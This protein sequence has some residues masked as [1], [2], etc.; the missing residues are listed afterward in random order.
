M[1]KWIVCVLIVGLLVLV[2]PAAAQEDTGIPI[3]YGDTVEGMIEP[4]ET[5]RY[6]FECQEGDVILVEVTSETLRMDVDVQT[7]AEGGSAYSN[8]YTAQLDGMVRESGRCGITVKASGLTDTGSSDPN[9]SGA[10]TL[11]LTLTETVDPDAEPDRF[12]ITY[13]ETLSYEMPPDGFIYFD[14]AGQVGDVVLATATGEGFDDDLYG[15]IGN[16]NTGWNETSR[17]LKPIE[18]STETVIYVTILPADG[19]YSMTLGNAGSSSGL[20]TMMLERVGNHSADSGRS[21]AYGEAVGAHLNTDL[22]QRWWFEGQAGDLADISVL[23]PVVTGGGIVELRV[24]A[25][26]GT[27]LNPPTF[28]D[29]F[30]SQSYT[31]RAVVK[32]P[33]TGT[34]RA[35]IVRYPQPGD[36]EI[37]PFDYV[38]RLDRPSATALGYGQM[39]TGELAS[40]ADSAIFTFEASA[41]D[42]VLVN[43]QSDDLDHITYRLSA[44]AAPIF[45]DGTYSHRWILLDSGPFTVEVYNDQG[46]YGDGG[47]FT[48][49]LEQFSTATITPISTGEPL[50]ISLDGTVAP[51]LS[52]EGKADDIVSV[53]VPSG[54]FISYTVVGGPGLYAEDVAAGPQSGSLLPYLRLPQDGTYYILPHNYHGQAPGGYTVPVLISQGADEPGIVYGETISGTIGADSVGIH[55][56]IGSAGDQVSALVQGNGFMAD[57]YLFGPGGL[58]STGLEVIKPQNIDLIPGVRLP[59]DGLYT[60]VVDDFQGFGG[61]SYTLTL[62]NG[63]AQNGTLLTSGQQVQGITLQPDDLHIYQFESQLGDLFRLSCSREVICDLYGPTR[64]YTGASLLPTGLTS[65][66]GGLYT[67]VVTSYGGGAATYDVSVRVSSPKVAAAPDTDADGLTDNLDRCPAESGILDGCPATDSD[68]DG[69]PDL[70]DACPDTAGTLNGCPD[71]DG[72]GIGDANDA[73]PDDPGSTAAQGCP[74]ADEDG[75]GDSEDA[76]PD[77]AGVAAFDGCPDTDGDGIQDSED[78]CPDAPGLAEFNGCGFYGSVGANANLRAG[79]GTEFD[80]VGTVTPADEILILGRNT[81]G[82]WLKVRV[83]DIDAWL[84]ASLVTTDT[85]IAALPVVE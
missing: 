43:L 13:G 16:Q 80:I 1:Q 20:V 19:D 53:E 47:A 83:G 31:R 64:H 4:G 71:T 12:P 35:E 7:S 11:A 74:D 57:L 33:Q 3:A 21:L 18:G 45:I 26:D 76:C 24:Y 5:D 46:A 6:T 32:L 48:L 79:T 34:Y 69:V 54:P 17:G 82:D 2:L 70:L 38:I 62:D 72:D 85:D 67:V 56:F 65:Q 61:G 15:Q 8:T 60:L 36:N 66:E 51:L 63:A 55:T 23:M 78:E 84:F 40:G 22:V 75:I 37:V 50:T 28:D 58:I 42:T 81:A 77:I 52:F 59:Q 30:V 44:P 27:Q 9:A 25:P 41:G 10:Y 29:M 49:G 68:G 73:C 39:H 14:F